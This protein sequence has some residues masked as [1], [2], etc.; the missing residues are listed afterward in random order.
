[1]QAHRRR[2]SSRADAA[3]LRRRLLIGFT[4]LVLAIM[5]WRI[6]A[7]SLGELLQ[8]SRPRA[9]LAWNGRDGDALAVVASGRMAQ[10]DGAGAEQAARAALAVDPLNGRAVQVLGLLAGAAG[11]TARADALMMQVDRLTKR[12]TV[13]EAWLF[14]LAMTGGRYSEAMDHADSLLRRRSGTT[15][16]LLSVLVDTAGFAPALPALAEKLGK[17]PPWRPLFFAA[18]GKSDGNIDPAPLL[19]ALDRAGTPLSAAEAQPLIAGMVRRGDYRGAVDFARKFVPERGLMADGDFEGRPGIAPFM[20]RFT[21]GDAGRAEIVAR[22]NGGKA[23]R[24]EPAARGKPGILAQQTLVLP[25]GSYEL[26]G[27]MEKSRTG[28]SGTAI[29]IDC[30][31]R[32]GLT[33]F[34]GGDPVSQGQWQAFSGAFA[35]PS[36]NCPAQTIEVLATGVV[37]AE[38]AISW[39][40]E[41]AIAAR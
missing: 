26:S 40:D 5:A 25:P 19:A 14:D 6:I 34:R 16:K 8:F 31:G 10:G 29:R 39:Y 23:L 4:V 13:A 30:V 17:S 7:V 35:V 9:A 11:Q 27:R 18:F 12:N 36:E 24:V 38:G 1:M 2:S 28:I 15:A 3:N 37:P 22:E 21:A 32:R 33:L 41:L 20:W